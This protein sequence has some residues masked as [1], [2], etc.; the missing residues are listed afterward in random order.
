MSPKNDEWAHRR[1]RL[2]KC[3]KH[4][5]HF[6]SELTSGCALCRKE[7]LISAPKKP[8][9]QFLLLLLT[10]LGLALLAA[11]L[12]N[13]VREDRATTPN[14]EEE[15]ATSAKLDPNPMRRQIEGLERALDQEQDTDLSSWGISIRSAVQELAA[16]VERQDSVLAKPS[17]RALAEWAGSIPEEGFTP[18]D[19]TTARATWKRIARRNFKSAPWWSSLRPRTKT[20][21]RITLLA[22]REAADNLVALADEGAAQVEAFQEPG[23]DELTPAGD[24]WT[25]FAADWRQEIET[26]SQRLPN[27]G[28]FASDSRFLVGVQNLRNALSMLRRL[29]ADRTLPSKSGARDNL[30]T[31]IAQAGEARATFDALLLATE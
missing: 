5:L 11:S 17:A 16:Q 29:A 2:I 13:N 28:E 30:E 3:N 10:L 7:G 6:D 9:P 18:N 4:G 1:R 19:L 20:K 31:A 24:G 12:F 22:Y 8:G 26:I 25:S 14:E 27:K 21:G 23:F 15:V